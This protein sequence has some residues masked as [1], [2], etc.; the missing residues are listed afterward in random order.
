[1]KQLFQVSHPD[2]YSVIHFFGSAILFCLLS[3]VMPEWGAFCGTMAMGIAFEAG[4]YDAYKSEESIDLA[5]LVFD[6]LGCI[7]AMIILN[8]F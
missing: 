7:F 6:C 8:G 5:D 1:M 3:L 2:G 4:Q